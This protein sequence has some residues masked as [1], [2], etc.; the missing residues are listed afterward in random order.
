MRAPLLLFFPPS[1]SSSVT[2]V[3]ISRPTLRESPPLLLLPHIMYYIPRSMKL[4]AISFSCPTDS[5]VSPPLAS[6]CLMDFCFPP[7]PW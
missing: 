5:P 1:H 3:S 2:R 6:E 7:P 4:S